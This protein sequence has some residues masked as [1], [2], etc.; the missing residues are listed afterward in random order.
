MDGNG[1]DLIGTVVIGT[2][3]LVTHIIGSDGLV[4]HIYRFGWVVRLVDLR[5]VSGG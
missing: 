5:H 3:G 2:D 1:M 4:M